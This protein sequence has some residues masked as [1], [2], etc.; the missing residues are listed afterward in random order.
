MTA[1]LLVEMKKIVANALEIDEGQVTD[2]LCSK[3]CPE[4]DSVR[5]VSIILMI[6][7]TFSIEFDDDDFNRANDFAAL[8]DL[9]REKISK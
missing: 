7:E 3:N 1:N 8:V 2:D 4:W 5:N 9:V 6:E